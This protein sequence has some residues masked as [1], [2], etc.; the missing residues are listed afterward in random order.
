MEAWN[1]IIESLPSDMRNKHFVLL[2]H[3][4][5]EVSQA[6]SVANV[7]FFHQLTN[8]L[9]HNRVFVGIDPL[10]KVVSHFQRPIIFEKDRGEFVL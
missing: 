1:D 9:H 8:P 4:P 3:P 5:L 2:R 7:P 10:A 6:F